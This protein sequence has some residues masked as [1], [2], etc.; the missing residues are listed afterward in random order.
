MN[1][2]KKLKVIGYVAL[3]IM[4]LNI[5]FFSLTL[6]SWLVFLI[7]LAVGYLFVKFGLPRIKEKL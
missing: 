6:Y 5:L 7:V 2:E 1:P 4:L 3:G